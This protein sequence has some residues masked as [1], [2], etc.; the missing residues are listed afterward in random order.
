MRAMVVAA[1]KQPLV[2]E[3]RPMPFPLLNAQAALERMLAG[4][5]RFRAVLDMDAR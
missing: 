1:P 4:K 2:L 3:N 5:A